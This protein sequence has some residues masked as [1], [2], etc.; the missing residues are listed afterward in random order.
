[1]SGEL[2]DR[3]IQPKCRY[4]ALCAVGGDGVLI[5]GRTNKAVP[6]KPCHRYEYDPL[7]RS[8]A[9]KPRLPEL[10]PELFDIV[11]GL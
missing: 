10:S 5:C 6:G 1:M 4:C 8:P 9:K 11:A 7:K 2:F 3:S